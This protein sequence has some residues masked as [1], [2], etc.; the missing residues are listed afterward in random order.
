MNCLPDWRDDVAVSIACRM[1]IAQSY[2]LSNQIVSLP[3]KCRV[4]RLYIKIN[5]MYNFIHYS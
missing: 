4:F 2:T 1:A 5:I 3:K